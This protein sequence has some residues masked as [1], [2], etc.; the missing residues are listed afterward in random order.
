MF[1]RP[2]VLF[3]VMCLVMVGMAACGGVNAGSSATPTTTHATTT[4]S[5]PTVQ[6]SSPAP[7]QV[8]SI[9]MSV[10]PASI[11]GLACGSN[12][13]VV[14]TATF[15][16]SPHSPGGV[17]QF[18]YTVNN[19]RSTTNASLNFAA[20]E[21]TKTY[22]FNWSGSLHADNVYPGNGGVITSSPNQVNSSMVKPT[23]TC[24]TAPAFQVTGVE[25]SVT[26]SSIAGLVCNTP[27][28]LVYTVTFHVTANSPGGT[29]Q[30]MYTT[31]NGRGNT[32]GSITFAAG[33]TKKIFTFSSSGILYPDHTFPGVAEVITTSPNQVN[34]PQ[35]KPAGA[36]S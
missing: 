30:F 17:V 14:Y 29:V 9:D 10:N 11:T 6:T 19:G 13:T 28:T 20:G 7:F 24:T 8:S 12:L 15:H 31:T 33:E 1:K 35:V 27:I 32:N 5:S 16:V 18:M 26:P 21:T 25:L 3:I 22:T 2:V 34:S 4:T 36:C 23:G